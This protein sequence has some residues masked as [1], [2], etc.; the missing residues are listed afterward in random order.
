MIMLQKIKNILKRILP[1]PIH[2]FNREITR[3]L[4][5]IANLRKAQNQMSRELQL[6]QKEQMKEISSVRKEQAQLI[7]ELTAVRKEQAQL[8]AELTAVHKD[9]AKLIA[10]LTSARKEHDQILAQN[11]EMRQI[12]SQKMQAYEEMVAELS[13]ENAELKQHFDR[14]LSGVN[15]E[16][17]R[18]GHRVIQ[19]FVR[20]NRYT[21]NAPI[22]SVLIPVYNVEAYLRE[23]L[24]S[25]LN[26]SMKHIEIICVDDGSTDSSGAILDE[27]ARKDIR[28][29]VI[30]KEKNAGL[31]LAR[32]TAVEAASGEYIL[33]VD[34]DDIV[35]PDMC[36]FA[37]EITRNE[38]ADII[39]FG[40]DVC[41]YANDAP[42]EAWL[43]RILTPAPRELASKEILREAYVTR[44]YGT[45]LWGKLYKTDLCKKA[46]AAL[47][48]TYCYVGEDIFT[49]FY[50]AYYAK[51]YKGIPTR[52]YYIY[53]HGL[54]VT[55]V[56]MMSL[57]KFEIYC[58][59][60]N[61]VKY[62]YN[63]LIHESTDPD[64]LDS[65]NAMVRRVSEDCCR[66]Y[67]S[68]IREEDKEDAWK[69]LTSYWGDNPIAEESAQKMLGY[70]LSKD[71]IVH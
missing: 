35:D 18:Q 66:I 70:P 36:A 9:Q 47:P 61:F 16:I 68:R 57:K 50:L 14:E 3:V 40:A 32:K 48:N 2:I 24:D 6:S 71:R 58:S 7:T 28:M 4:D 1:P 13:R 49:Y 34:S 31:L 51:S 37:E 26:Q 69:M 62:I 20:A 52:P 8:I 53:R 5:V 60:A 33:F 45:S 54:G 12:F 23:C 41:D 63:K 10:E 38:Y 21:A 25:V 46:Y 43:R 65:F 30:H 27:Y 64:L 17:Q 22:L 56:D 42:K 59:M 15:N 11:V 29:K 39:H 19:T 67:G 55:N 44:S